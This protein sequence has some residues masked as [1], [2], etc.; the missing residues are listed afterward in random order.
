MCFDRR[1]HIDRQYVRFTLCETCT[2][3]ASDIAD[4]SSSSIPV[5]PTSV[6]DISRL[7]GREG[8]GVCIPGIQLQVLR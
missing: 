2:C 6:T 5:L 8:G 4:S 1:R 7:M 3:S